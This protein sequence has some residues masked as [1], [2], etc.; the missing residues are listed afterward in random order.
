MFVDLKM[1]LNK[2]NHFKATLVFEKA[3]TVEVEYDVLAIGAAPK[4]GPSTSKMHSH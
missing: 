1:P 4:G 3:G 2:D